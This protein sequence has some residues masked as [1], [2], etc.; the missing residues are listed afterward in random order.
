MMMA[1]ISEQAQRYGVTPEEARFVY[2]VQQ[3]A[4]R[5]DQVTPEQ[6]RRVEAIQQKMV[7]Q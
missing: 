7:A 5:G 6:R 3:A 1:A 4:R 2:D